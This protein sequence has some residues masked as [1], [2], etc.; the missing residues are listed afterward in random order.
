MK[1]TC[2]ALSGDVIVEVEENTESLVKQELGEYFKVDPRRVTLFLF[3][4]IDYGVII[5]EP[6][7]GLLEWIPLEK[8]T[9]NYISANPRAISLLRQYPDKINWDMASINPN[10]ID[11][12]RENRD[13]I[14]WCQFAANSS[15]DA[16][17]L[18]EEYLKNGGGDESAFDGHPNEHYLFWTRLSENPNALPLLKQH[19]EEIKWNSLLALNTNPD[20]IPFVQEHL[21]LEEIVSRLSHQPFA[22]SLLKEHPEHIDWY[23]MSSNPNGISLLESFIPQRDSKYRVGW[24]KI[25]KNPEAISLIEQNMDMVV[26]YALS[27]NPNALHILKNH[28]DKICWSFLCYNTNPEAIELIEQNI[29]QLN[30]DPMLECDRDGLTLSQ[31]PAALPFLSRHPQ[32]IQWHVLARLPEIFEWIE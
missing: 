24:D 12:L 21:Y 10:A 18:L 15:P 4:D 1:L 5:Q 25:C 2:R 27:R 19:I 23:R 7:W 17:P 20:I 29:H 28:M 31:N 26:W 9:W 3:E 30:S 14:V 6:Y 13:K 8:L 16:I 22:I 32:F 11:M